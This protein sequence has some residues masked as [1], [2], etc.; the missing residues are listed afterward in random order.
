M[1]FLSIKI[2]ERRN[3]KDNNKIENLLLLIEIKIREIRP[4]KLY[5]KTEDV[6]AIA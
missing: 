2:V 5:A 4:K 1:F 6:S 3:D